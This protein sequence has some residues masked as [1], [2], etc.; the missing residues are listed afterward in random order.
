MS[1]LSNSAAQ[2]GGMSREDELAALFG[3]LVVQQA[4]MALML[5]GKVAN[6]ETGKPTKDLDAAR[7]FVDQVEMLEAKTKGNLSPQEANLVKQT[8]MTLRMAFVEAVENPDNSPAAEPA[9]GG[10][11]QPAAAAPAP[12]AAPSSDEEGRVKFTKKY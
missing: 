3:N 4:Q 9:K 7:Y 10:A 12:S 8:L 1:E 6:P 5:M 2:A 11:D